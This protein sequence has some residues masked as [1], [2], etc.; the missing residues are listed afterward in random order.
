MQYAANCG[1]PLVAPF[2]NATP[3][4][5]EAPCPVR[6]T[7]PDR[8]LKWFLGPNME[9]DLFFCDCCVSRMQKRSGSVARPGWLR[10]WIVAKLLAEQ[11]ANAKFARHEVSLPTVLTQ[12][13]K[14]RKKVLVVATVRD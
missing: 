10:K 12:I 13:L 4:S 1:R 14:E 9:I 3:S 2:S 5:D 8:Y 6:G 11:R 7:H